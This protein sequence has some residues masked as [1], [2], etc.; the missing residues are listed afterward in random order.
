MS[1]EILYEKNMGT[2]EKLKMYTKRIFFGIGMFTGLALLGN[3]KLQSLVER[4]I[5]E[6]FQNE[7]ASRVQTVF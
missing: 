1:T 2:K 4:N 3:F 7:H 5:Y 6:A